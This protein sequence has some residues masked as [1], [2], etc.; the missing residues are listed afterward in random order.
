MNKLYRVGETDNIITIQ[1]DKGRFRVLLTRGKDTEP[2]E[3]TSELERVLGRG[4]EGGR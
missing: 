3:G 1:C 4:Q 2:S